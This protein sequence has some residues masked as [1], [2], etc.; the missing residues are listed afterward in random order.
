[1]AYFRGADWKFLPGRVS[2][3]RDGEQKIGLMWILSRIPAGSLENMLR[4]P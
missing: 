2:T 1:M 4:R 3:R